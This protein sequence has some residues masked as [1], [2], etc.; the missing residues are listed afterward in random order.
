MKAFQK[1][2]IERKKLLD[3]LEKELLCGGRD[4]LLREFQILVVAQL[5]LETVKEEMCGGIATTNPEIVGVIERI[6]AFQRTEEEGFSLK[7]RLIRRLLKAGF[8]L[9]VMELQSQAVYDQKTIFG[10]HKSMDEVD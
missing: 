2:D 9:Y 10:G 4:I 1:R 3:E 6:N 7:Y 8:R 5:L